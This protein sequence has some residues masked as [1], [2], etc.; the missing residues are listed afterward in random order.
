MYRGTHIALPAKIAGFNWDGG[1]R[2]KCG[3]HGVSAGEI[4]A[5]FRR[6]IALL[7]DPAHS[8]AEARIRAVGKTRGGR[9]VFLVFTLRRRDG[10]TWIRPISARYMHRKEIERYEQAN[11]DLQE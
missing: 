7:P 10:G 5:L 9:Y 8:L 1:N 3:K 6:P 2:E 4:E 11:P